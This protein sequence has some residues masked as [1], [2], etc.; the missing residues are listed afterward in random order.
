MEELVAA[1]RAALERLRAA[2]LQQLR[3]DEEENAAASA[4]GLPIIIIINIL[5]L[6]CYGDQHVYVSDLERRCLDQ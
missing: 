3:Q 1:E 2:R 4:V 5:L 6:I